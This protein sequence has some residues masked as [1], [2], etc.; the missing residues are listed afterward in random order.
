[1]ASRAIGS[2]LHDVDWI[3]H[4]CSDDDDDGRVGIG[5]VR[6]GSALEPW[7]VSYGRC[8]GFQLLILLL[9]SY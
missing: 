7:S 2:L 1:M 5:R 3:T 8:D 9:N 4:Q 6:Y